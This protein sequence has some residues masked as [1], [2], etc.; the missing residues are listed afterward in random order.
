MGSPVRSGKQPVTFV[1]AFLVSQGSSLLHH[2]YKQTRDT[3]DMSRYLRRH[4]GTHSPVPVSAP[5]LS[6]ECLMYL[7]PPDSGQFEG[8]WAD[9]LLIRTLNTRQGFESR[10]PAPRAFVLFLW[11]CSLCVQNSEENATGLITARQ[12]RRETDGSTGAEDGHRRVWRASPLL[13][14][15]RVSSASEREIRWWKCYHKAR[16]QSREN[17]ASSVMRVISSESKKMGGLTL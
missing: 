13:W 10:S 2:V 15:A 1:K 4:P 9:R 8:I 5:Q 7:G 16:C 12:P 11:K 17:D 14:C 6:P 3:R